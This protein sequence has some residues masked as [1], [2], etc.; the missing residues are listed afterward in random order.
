MG[1]DIQLSGLIPARDGGRHRFICRGFESFRQETIDV[2]EIG[3][4]RLRVR[5]RD[6]MTLVALG[7]GG[8]SQNASH[9]PPAGGSTCGRLLLGR[10]R[11]PYAP[12]GTGR[13][14]G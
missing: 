13:P 1:S 3:D 2:Q 6:V 11:T 12:G 8:A 14:P 7:S 9:R 4:P 5:M 10:S